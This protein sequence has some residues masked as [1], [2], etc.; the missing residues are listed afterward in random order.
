MH[1]LNS[2][3]SKYI[4]FLT[5][6]LVIHTA[7]ASAQNGKSH[8]APTVEMVAMRDSV[9]LATSIFKF[10]S[11]APGPAILIRTPSNH[12]DYQAEISYFLEKRY[13]V[14]IQST[15]GRNGSE[16]V[17]S[18]FFNDGWGEKQDGFDTVEWIAAQAWNNGK[19]GT[20]GRGLDGFLQIL[21]AGSQPPN[22]TAQ[23]IIA[24]PYN[25]YDHFVFPDGVWRKSLVENSLEDL[26]ADSLISLFANN[27]AYSAFWTQ[28]NGV[29]RAKA[30]NVPVAFVTGWYDAFNK[31]TI[32]AYRFIKKYGQDF[33]NDNVFLRVG[34][35]TDNQSGFGKRR[36]GEFTFPEN[37]KFDVLADAGNWFDSWLK[38]SSESMMLEA[39]VKYYQMG[40][41]DEAYAAGNIWQEARQW[42]PAPKE[43]A[44]FYLAKDGGL[45][46]NEIDKKGA[47]EGF[48]YDPANPVPTRGG[49][50]MFL[51]AGP[52]DQQNTES[53]KDV[54]IYTTDV[55]EAPVAT[56]GRIR[57]KLFASSSAFDTDFT[58]KLTDVY[59]DGR[60]M[61]LTDGVVRARFRESRTE[62]KL[63]KPKKVYEFWIDLGY[64]AT[65]FN[66]GH[67]IRIAISSSN[68]PRFEPNPNSPEPFRQN[69]KAIIATNTVYFGGKRA[70]YLELPIVSLP[71]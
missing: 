29:R 35:W 9:K 33:A 58:V 11:T 49:D 15:R 37:A 20:F 13:H 31:G 50:N 55:L 64:T 47:A 68:S 41:V 5:L 60:S 62:P 45:R 24:A 63:L 66:T 28:L 17:D 34:P 10:D 59:P 52:M 6:F 38:S 46:K 40:A 27:P 12:E 44:K 19:V 26:K 67:K 7:G 51:E 43:I 57:L 8:P 53:R 61:L 39:P 48:M 3:F 30:V 70:S 4:R 21:L 2:P 18:L 22:L 32:D 71:E 65:V 69:A 54:L 25:L 56:A 14:I 1:A 36:Q 42:P 23:Y 16:G